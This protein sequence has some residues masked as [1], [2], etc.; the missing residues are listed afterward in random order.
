VKRNFRFA[1][2]S[3]ICVCFV[4]AMTLFSMAETKSPASGQKVKITGT[5]VVREGEIVQIRDEKDGSVQ[6]FKVTDKTEIRRN[7]GFLHGNSTLDAS[8]L[9]P[10]LTVK[11]Y[12]VGTPE[13]TPE[14]KRIHFKAEAFSVTVAQEKQI[15]E[16]QAA[17]SHAQTTADDGV[18][19]AANAQSSADQAQSSANQGIATAQAAGTLAASN[20]VGVEMLNQRV[21]DLGDYNTLAETGIYF[22]AGSHALSAEAKKDLDQLVTANSGVNGYIVEITGYASSEGGAS[23]NQKLSEA[24]AAAVAEYL[25]V[26]ADVP[27][28]RIAVPAGYGATHPAVANDNPTDR[29]MN[30]RVEV[31]ILVAK[32][33]EE[34][35][36]SQSLLLGSKN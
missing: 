6:P 16:N 12:G 31:R 17:A 36:T 24:R 9:V 23:Y 25:R 14:A 21:A 26:H 2:L 19:A 33:L 11:V 8:A 27:A 28:A 15:K 10:G 34:G 5:I 1:F 4:A 29:A 3:A 35:T 13:G 7:K 22:K 20:Q 30:R 32:G 18:A